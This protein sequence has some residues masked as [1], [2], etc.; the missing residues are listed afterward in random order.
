MG[1][2]SAAITTNSLMPRFSVLVAAGNDA[3]GRRSISLTA[4]SRR[5]ESRPPAPGL[6]SLTL[7]STLLQLL[8]VGRLLDNVQDGVGQLCVRQRV[9]LRVHSLGHG[10]EG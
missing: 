2:V 4:A 1:S 3:T 5:R 6:P 7:V 9:R 10:G 8:V